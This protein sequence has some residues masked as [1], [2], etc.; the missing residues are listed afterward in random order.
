LATLRHKL[1]ET[2]SELDRLQAQADLSSVAALR[3]ANGDKD[4]PQQPFFDLSR[5]RVNVGLYFPECAEPF[6]DYDREI[7]AAVRQMRADFGADA[8]GA[9]VTYQ[10]LS[11][12]LYGAMATKLR[13]LLDQRAAEISLTTTQSQKKRPQFRSKIAP[14]KS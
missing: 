12:G 9:M 10:L 14:P 4:V 13:K 3:L 5:V 8:K 6:A 7:E 11:F 1:E 2:Y